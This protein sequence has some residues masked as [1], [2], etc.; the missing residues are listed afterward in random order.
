MLRFLLGWLAW[1]LTASAFWVGSV[2]ALMLAPTFLLSPLFGITADRID[3]RNGLLMTIGLQSLLAAIACVVAFMGAM[4]LHA[5]AGLALALGAI[6]SAHT[7][8]RLA[9]I[10]RLVARAALPSAIGYSAM[11]FNTSRIIGPALGAWLLTFTSFSV[12]LGVAACICAGACL[13]VA[14]LPR[15]AS[16]QTAHRQGSIF[17]Q[18]RAGLGYLR[19]E[20]AIRLVFLLTM[21]SGFL[22]RTA[23]ELLPAISGGMLEGTSATLA[24]LTSAAGVGSIVG[25]L[26]VSR[27][28]S[29]LPK[30]FDF[31]L[32]ALLAAACVLLSASFWTSLP[33]ASVAV[34]LISLC[35]T[36][37]GTGCQ[38]ITQLTVDDGYRG[39][40]MS[41]WTVVAMGTPAIGAVL[42]GT[43]ADH[44]GFAVA[45]IATACLAVLVVV[46]AWSRG[47]SFA[48]P[49]KR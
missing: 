22:G 25:G 17:T 30:L 3:P 19:D 29:H 21:A 44:V 34:A 45:F 42:V 18:L 2:A 24:V 33:I 15:T 16:K 27:Q 4:Q 5:L 37:I 7:P 26:I 20:T 48:I 9:L 14:R 41:L 31:V 1:E 39:R 13:L 46:W 28:S 40:V 32:R 23:I 47:A 11:V 36:V 6:S 8:I 10:P 43:A 35:T 12:A 49:A 38:A